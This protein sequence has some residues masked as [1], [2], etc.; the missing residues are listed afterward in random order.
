MERFRVAH[1]RDDGSHFARLED[2]RACVSAGMSKGSTLRDDRVVQPEVGY[3]RVLRGVFTF[4]DTGGTCGPLELLCLPN[5]LGAGHA[6][7]ICGSSG[8]SPRRSA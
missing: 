5:G 2:L 1:L 4:P 7:R 6:K 8:R 3:L